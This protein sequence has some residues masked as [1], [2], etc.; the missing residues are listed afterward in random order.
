MATYKELKSQAE[1]L[2]VQAEEAR[3]KELADAIE[4]IR[5]KMKDHG[6]TLRDLGGGRGSSPAAAR[7]AKRRPAA[8]KYRDKAGNTWTGRG[9]TPRWLQ[10]HL[11]AG[12][13][14]E[15]FAV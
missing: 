1:K 12:K 7:T 14:V 2:M 8:V 3:Q 11:D 6:I 13:S 5:T 4:E 15:D 10:A 9:R